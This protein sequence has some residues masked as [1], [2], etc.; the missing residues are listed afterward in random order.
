ME[1]HNG[2]IYS[3]ENEWTRATCINLDKSQ[4][5]VDEKQQKVIMYTAPYYFG[6]VLKYKIVAHIVYGYTQKTKV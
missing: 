6:I 2:M 3:N 5:K 4:R 1:L